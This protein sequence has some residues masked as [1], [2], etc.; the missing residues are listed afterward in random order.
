MYRST[1]VIFLLFGLSFSM[2][3][4]RPASADELFKD[5]RVA[6]FEENNY[7][8]AK[9]IAYQALEIAPSY[10][11][12]E[13]FL[14]R[15][16]TWNK[17]YD[18][19]RYHFTKVLAVEPANEDASVAYTDLEYWNDH[20]EKALDICNQGLTFFP[21]SR[22]LLF[23][24]AKILDATKN[25]KEANAVIN[26]LQKTNQDDK[27]V[28]A[29]ANTIKSETTKNKLGITYDHSSFD[30]QYDKAWHLVSVAYSHQT[31]IGT[32][33]GRVN[34]AN[35]FGTNGTQAEIDAYPHISK[36]F[37]GYINFG[38]SNSNGVFPKYRAGFSIYANLPN[39]FEG[40]IGLRHL[41]FSTATNIYTA[42]LGKYYNNFLFTARTYITPSN[43]AVSQSY[44]LAARYYLKGADDY[45]GITAGT[46]ISPDDSNQ[47]L[48]FSNKQENL[49][50][51]KVSVDYSHTFL[52]RNILTLGAGWINQ[53]YLPSIRGNQFDLNI[54]LSHRF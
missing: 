7:A 15:V 30:K 19:A 8:K 38:Y 25:Y 34:Y 22:P 32:V 42:S 31:N 6:A 44:S 48:Q 29:L 50:S 33:I 4:Q 11:D 21:S 13:I 9:E 3:A 51:R 37:Y 53:E 1:L 41:Y 5:A 49:S 39:S 26:E 35:R 14:G 40:E 18:S 43:S 24:K 47:N 20:Y 54:G 16:Y 52:N 46:G 10:A 17:Q 2:S 12:I 27:E 23:R 45:V 28:L 36:T